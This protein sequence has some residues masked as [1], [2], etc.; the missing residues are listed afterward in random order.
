MTAGIQPTEMT[1]VQL[2]CLAASAI[3][4]AATNIAASTAMGASHLLSYRM[5]GLL[6]SSFLVIDKLT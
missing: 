3:A 4:L 6:L 5:T 1:G 2:P